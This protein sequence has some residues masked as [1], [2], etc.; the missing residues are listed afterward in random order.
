MTIWYRG[1]AIGLALCLAPGCGERTEP[2]HR[3][4][5]KVELPGADVAL[6]EGHVV[7]VVHATD[8][9]V[10]ASGQIGPDGRFELETLHRGAI[11]KGALEGT[12]QV[13]LILSDDDPVARKKAAKV[14]PAKYLKF[15]TSGLTVE[16]PKQRDAVLNLA[17][18]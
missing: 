3:V 9:K 5:G 17:A 11:R 16:V 7:E 4:R 12:Y 1:I 8:P 2:T 6:L 15:E 10:R 13:R 18:R 14:I